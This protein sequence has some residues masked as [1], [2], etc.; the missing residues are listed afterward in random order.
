MDGATRIIP[1]QPLGFPA[2]KTASGG[3]IRA[4]R[5]APEKMP[6][7]RLYRLRKTQLC[8]Y[9]PAGPHILG[10]TIGNAVANGI[11]SSQ[12]TSA[13]GH[14]G[15]GVQLALNDAVPP[16][17]GQ[18][19]VASDYPIVV[20]APHGYTAQ[21]DGV[22]LYDFAKA[23]IAGDSATA[24]QETDAN[25]RELEAQIIQKNGITDVNNINDGPLFVPT[26]EFTPSA[27]A[28]SV[29]NGISYMPDSAAKVGPRAI[30]YN[31][32]DGST[33][34]RTGGTLPWRA[35]NP[36]DI[37][38]GNFAINHGAIGVFPNPGHTPMA[39]FPDVETGNSAMDALLRTPTYQGRTIDSA[40]ARYAPSVENNTAAYQALLTNTLGVPGSTP[41]SSLNQQQMSDLENA[42]R[43]QEGFYN[44]SAVG[45]TQRGP[46]N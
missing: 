46:G 37:M 20:T 5:I 7:N 15:G 29:L 17:P 43:T 44:R 41:M 18:Q 10:N 38:Y 16:L 14:Q 2:P 9:D 3:K 26:T 30:Q 39:I 45:T 36:G 4:H 35:N 33:E 24:G 19:D 6:R 1:S 12:D 22:S 28:Y 32:P 40:V 8:N 13:Q 23:Q 25:V 27:S 42:I 31:F 34:T 11:A 21:F